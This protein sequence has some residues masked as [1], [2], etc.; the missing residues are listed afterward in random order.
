[1]PV[2]VYGLRHPRTKVIRY[3]GKT[4][5][6][7]AGRVTGHVYQARS[8][9]TRTPVGEW[10]RRLQLLELRPEG[11]LLATATDQ[12][13]Q[14]IE[15]ATIARLKTNGYRLLN[16]NR[17]GNG[18][19]KRVR[20][21]AEH[22]AKIGVISDVRLAKLTG[23]TRE[24]IKYHRNRLGLP[25]AFQPTRAGYKTGRIALNATTL[26]ASLVRKL[27]KQ[28][29]YS[30]ACIAGVSRPTI[31]TK[32][33]ALG[34]SVYTGPKRMPVGEAHHSSKLTEKLVIWLRKQ[35]AK[36]R[37]CCGLSRQLNV[38]MSIVWRAIRRHT[39]RHLQ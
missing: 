34:I 18:A 17:G 4:C 5:Q 23:L 19:H 3:V 29:D 8:W 11:V 36:G 7:L 25:A 39:W 38:S 12:N 30:I 6:T 2:I 14:S 33:R 22:A 20:L 37:S 9:R 13:W 24:A 31:T 16:I 21:S 10:I 35:Y 15:R 27:G 28:S 1:M 32:R 26:P